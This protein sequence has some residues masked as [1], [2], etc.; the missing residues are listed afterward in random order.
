MTPTVSV[1]TPAYNAAAVVGE[2]IRSLQNQ[3]FASWE[4]LVVDDCS[5]DD[6]AAVIAAFANNDERIRLLRSAQ[7]AGPANARN[8]AMTAARGRYMAFLDSD[9]LW[10]PEKLQLQLAFMAEKDAA[11]SYTAYRRFREDPQRAGPLVAARPEFDYRALLKNP[12]MACLTVM[13]DRER[14]GPF[15]MPSVR[16]E[17]YALWLSLL[18][19]GLRSHGLNVDL[20]RYR[21]SET[22]V[23][24]NKLRSAKWVWDIYRNSER[25]RLPHASWCLA[26]YAIHAVRK[27][28]GE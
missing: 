17:D 2:A 10:L 22:S 18:R 23:S 6:T 11:L 25:L 3:T 5:T 28:R 15:T 16:H 19:G 27:R 14:T 21:I 4:M 13:V 26:H 9:D 7:N 12:G 1:I 24:S 8:V 20:A